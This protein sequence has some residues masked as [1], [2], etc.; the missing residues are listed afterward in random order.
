MTKSRRERQLDQT[1]KL[2]LLYYAVTG[3]AF[4]LVMAWGNSVTALSWLFVATIVLGGA[5][6]LVQ[7]RANDEL[8]RL[9]IVKSC[10][11]VGI[12]NMFALCAVLSW[13]ALRLLPLAGTVNFEELPIPF[14]PVYLLLLLDALILSGAH[15]YLRWQD[16]RA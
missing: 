10:A 2:E 1:R 5:V 4:V 12:F 15:A 13:Y 9:R 7:Y 16:E 8:G 6:W 14:W 11:A 3:L